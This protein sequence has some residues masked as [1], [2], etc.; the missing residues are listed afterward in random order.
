MVV[1]VAG[2]LRDRSVPVDT[3]LG[4]ICSAALARIRLLPRWR[5][6]G[7]IGFSCGGLSSAEQRRATPTCGGRLL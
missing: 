5:P 3:G 2:E 7:R 1:M 6:V 4:R